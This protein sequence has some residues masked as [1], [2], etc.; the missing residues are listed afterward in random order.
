M[1]YHVR[2]ANGTAL[3]ITAD[4]YSTNDQ[5]IMFTSATVDGGNDLVAVVPLASLAIV[6]TA[7]I[8]ASNAVAPDVTPV[9]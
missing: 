3:T 7:P 9:L 2:L 5:L 1:I 4:G 6:T 8:A